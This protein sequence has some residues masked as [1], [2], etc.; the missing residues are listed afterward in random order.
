M[1]I[2]HRSTRKVAGARGAAPK[3]PRACPGRPPA[4][5][6]CP[7]GLA[8]AAGHLGAKALKDTPIISKLAGKLRL[9]C[10]QVPFLLVLAA[11][12]FFFL[13]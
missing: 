12:S 4:T 13:R 6:P 9:G 3:S 7:A 5:A 11:L 8:S 2:A 1:Q 10:S